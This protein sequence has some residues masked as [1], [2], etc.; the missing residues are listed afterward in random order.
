ME[1]RLIRLSV[2]IVFLLLWFSNQVVLDV[3]TQLWTRHLSS[4]SGTSMQLG[5]TPLLK[6][7]RLY[8]TWF[9][10]SKLS[11]RVKYKIWLGNKFYLEKGFSSNIFIVTVTLAQGPKFFSTLDTLIKIKTELTDN[12]KI[13]GLS[14]LAVHY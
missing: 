8:C 14:H 4:H 11:N 6:F 7:Y 2:I 13:K 9:F 1:I 3:R 5:L 12:V 10:M